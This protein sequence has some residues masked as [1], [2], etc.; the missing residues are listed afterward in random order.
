MNGKFM[1]VD[2]YERVPVFALCPE[3]NNAGRLRCPQHFLSSKTFL[4]PSFLIDAC[5]KKKAHKLR[6][7]M[8]AQKK[9]SAERKGHPGK[10]FKKGL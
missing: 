1:S 4:N 8:K 7:G 3:K 5:R 10:G 9:K 6:W 2:G